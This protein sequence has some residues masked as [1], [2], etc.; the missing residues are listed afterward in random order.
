MGLLEFSGVPLEWTETKKLSDRVREHGV[1]QFINI[2]NQ[3]KDKQHP[4]LRWGDE[5]IAN[6]ASFVKHMASDAELLGF[7]VQVEY[8]V[9]AFDDEKKEAV[10]SLRSPELL[11]DL[12]LFK[13]KLPK[14]NCARDIIWHPEFAN[15]MLEATPGQ[16]YKETAADLRQYPH[17]TCHLRARLVCW[18]S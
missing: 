7:V 3:Y 6:M 18:L 15:W 1:S 10:L 13:A 9:M 16:P 17:P 14:C 11:E 12:Q 8:F 5:V 4:V 2:Y